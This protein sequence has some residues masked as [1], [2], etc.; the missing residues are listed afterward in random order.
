MKLFN[1]MTAALLLGTFSLKAEVPELLKL[2]P[3]AK[4]Y[5]LI[6]KLNPL[7]WKAK[8]YAVNNTAKLSGDL[9]RVGYLLVL[10]GK[11]GK[12]S[13][14]FTSM[15]A[16]A[17][18]AD[19]VIVPTRKSKAYQC[20]VNNLE[21]AGNV[22]GLKTGKFDKGNIE[23]WGTN[24]GGNNAKK[25]PGAAQTY[26]FGDQAVGNGNYGSMQVHNYLQK[27]TV[28]AFNHMDVNASC[29]LGIGNNPKGQPDWTFSNAGKNYKNAELYIVGQFKNK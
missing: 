12:T 6:A 26:D 5:E 10:T 2:V 11:D 15:D 25:I 4:G 14:V 19:Q 18:T 27:Q 22:A 20:Y 24:Y 23:F 29:D 13:W 1:W 7:N 3:E 28:F 9:T 17:K 21:V 16:F 8:G